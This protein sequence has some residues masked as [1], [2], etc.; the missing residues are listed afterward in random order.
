[1]SNL[2]GIQILYKK[3]NEIYYKSS[4]TYKNKHISLGS[5]KSPEIA[6]AVYLEAYEIVFNFK[7]KFIDFSKQMLIPFEKWVIL[8]NFKDNKYYIGKPI[9][10]YKS[11]FCYYLDEKI[12]F[13]FNTEDLF[14]YATHKIHC[15]NNYYYVNDH[16]EQIN[17][18]SRYNIKNYA[19]LNKDYFFKNGDIHD[20]RSFN[21]EIINKYNGVTMVVKKNKTLYISKIHNINDVLVGIYNTEIEAAIAYN[22]A[23]DLL[24]S[25]DINKDVN[26]NYIYCLSSD[27]YKELYKKTKISSNII[28]KSRQKRPIRFCEY[29]GVHKQKTGY[30]AYIGYNY[31][32]I[33]LGMYSNSI[34]AAQAYN[35]AALILYKD[36]ANLN[37]TLP[38]VNAHDYNKIVDK[39]RHVFPNI[40]VSII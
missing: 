23:I 22:K 29:T 12:E 5:Y 35:Q 1:M 7:Y 26:K 24:K 13:K 9:Y 40:D 15:R 16:G 21:L 32:H 28:K 34:Q 37:H 2:K 19:V 38:T 11:Y 36:K 18:L 25:Y 3:N 33:Y 31:K 14:F 4:I 6:H 20:F 8:H 17:I 30:R 10:L 39:I 27:Q